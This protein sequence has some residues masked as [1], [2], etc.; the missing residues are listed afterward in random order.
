MAL[1]EPEMEDQSPAEDNLGVDCDDVDM[2]DNTVTPTIT[3]TAQTPTQMLLERFPGR[4]NEVM[5]LRSM[6]QMTR[7]EC[8]QPIFIYGLPSTGKTTVVQGVFEATFQHCRNS[9]AYVNCFETFNLRLLFDHILSQLT[10]EPADFSFDGDEEEEDGENE[11]QLDL[12]MGNG[13]DG[14]KVTRRCDSLNDFVNILR[15]IC[16]EEKTGPA[17]GMDVDTD[18]M[19]EPPATTITKERALSEDPVFIHFPQY[20]KD[21]LS[22]ASP[23]FQSTSYVHMPVVL[24]SNC[25]HSLPDMQSILFLDCP[26]DADRDLFRTFVELVVNVLEK[27][28]KNLSE[29]RY[30]IRLLYPKYTEPVTRGHATKEQTTRLYKHIQTYFKDVLD[31]LYTRQISSAEWETTV[32]KEKSDKISTI[33]HQSA[34][35]ANLPDNAVYLLFASFI[36]SYNP[37]R[38]DVRFFSK[39]SEGRTRQS[40]TIKKVTKSKLRQ[41]LLGPK[42]FPVERMLAIFFS[43]M[44]EISGRDVESVVDLHFQGDLRRDLDDVALNF[45]KDLILLKPTFL[46]TLKEGY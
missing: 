17:N 3:T 40:K 12:K 36:A 5:L 13:G 6:I 28:C 21:I 35:D 29:M 19:T 42:A 25:S 8:M 26:A 14:G 24:N 11:A 43:I 30:I 1:E 10:S 9:Y 7:L 34:V 23:V 46:T 45:V 22:N 44:N 4:S 39:S 20:S 27:P 15:D 18:A 37:P 32:S 33:I 16:R 31:K 2:V 41:Q 38:F